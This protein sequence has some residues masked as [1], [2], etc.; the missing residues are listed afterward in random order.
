MKGYPVGKPFEP[1]SELSFI[2]HKLRLS[3]D[4]Y[5]AQQRVDSGW[6]AITRVLNERNVVIGGP[7]TR[8]YRIRQNHEVFA[9]VERQL[10]DVFGHNGVV[11]CEVQ[12]SVARKGGLSVRQYIFWDEISA[13]LGGKSKLYFRVITIN[14]FNKKL[15]FIT[16]AGAIDGFCTNGNIFGE[17]TEN[18]Q[19]HV[20]AFKLERFDEF[21][22]GALAEFRG[23]LDTA[24]RLRAYHIGLNEA[25]DLLYELPSAD[26]QKFKDNIGK[27]LADNIAYHDDT[28]WAVYSTATWWASTDDNTWAVPDTDSA[29]ENAIERKIKRQVE[30]RNW[31]LQHLLPLLDED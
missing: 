10:S 30:V 31:M 9:E 25:F 3:Y 2:A 6:Y 5:V 13:L 20:G 24:N 7:V 19:R 12:D 23:F 16:Y 8:A 27:A 11:M 29:R 17:Y 15:P 26:T 21:L 28:L 1:V 22:R 4:D 18:K 14:S